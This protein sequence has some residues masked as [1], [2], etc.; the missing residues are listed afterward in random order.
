MYMQNMSSISRD[1]QKISFKI[2]RKSIV[3][4]NVLKNWVAWNKAA[5]NKPH[6]QPY[7]FS[8]VPLILEEREKGVAFFP[9]LLAQFMA[10]FLFSTL[11][12]MHL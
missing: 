9:P 2:L 4:K 12:I 5:I 1:I 6:I 7:I 10:L 11:C 8:G 3:P